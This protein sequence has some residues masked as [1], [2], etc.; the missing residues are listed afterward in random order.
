MMSEIT[1]LHLSDVHFKCKDKETTPTFRQDVTT[2]MIEAIQQHLDKYQVV[3]DVLA[4]T[5]DIA[6]SGKE[7][8]EAKLF[9]K[10]LKAVL[11]SKTEFLAV[12]GN[13]DVERDKVDP[14]FPLYETIIE[15]ELIDGFLNNEKHIR[16]FINVKFKNFRAFIHEVI[17]GLYALNDDYFWVKDFHENN[18]LW[19]A[20]WAV[21]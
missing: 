6:F 17:P 16:D 21:L 10:D 15:K 11:P 1:I 8:D 3:P 5:G 12:P 13:H 2:K 18:G 7:Y 4:V 20:M 9:F 19:T 14:L